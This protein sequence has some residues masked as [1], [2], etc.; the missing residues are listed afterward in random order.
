[1]QPIVFFIVGSFFY[2]LFMFLLSFF[3]VQTQILFY[4]SHGWELPTR[5]I[6][7]EVSRETKFCFHSLPIL[8]G[9]DY[10]AVN[11]YCFN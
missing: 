5:E 9:I 7:Y 11:I 6:L 8:L 3:W 10:L 1:M 4:R 2:K